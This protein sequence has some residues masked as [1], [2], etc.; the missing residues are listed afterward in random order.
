M[1]ESFLFLYETSTLLP[2][3]LLPNKKQSY[4]L[5]CFKSNTKM[6]GTLGIV[7]DWQRRQ[8]KRQKMQDLRVQ[9]I[10]YIHPH[11]LSEKKILSSTSCSISLIT[12]FLSVNHYVL[13]ISKAVCSPPPQQ[14]PLQSYRKQHALL[15]GKPMM[16]QPNKFKS[17]KCHDLHHSWNMQP[18]KIPGV[19]MPTS[20]KILESFPTPL[21]SST[22]CGKKKTKECNSASLA[23]CCNSN[24]TMSIHDSTV[25]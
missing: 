7:S 18:T 10:L 23:L 1:L 11:T 20:G 9:F 22:P 2:N 19:P 24:V 4:L 5:E 14:Q 17:S 6:Y 12:L 13:A 21:H 8:N 16:P 3:S 15:F 25:L